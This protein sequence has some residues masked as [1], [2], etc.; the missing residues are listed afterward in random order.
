[1]SE[2]HRRPSEEVC[3]CKCI[4][5]ELPG[6]VLRLARFSWRNCEGR[7]AAA[8]R[9]TKP[10]TAALW[11]TSEPASSLLERTLVRLLRGEHDGRPARRDARAGPAL[12]RS[13]QLVGGGL[14]EIPR[15]VYAAHP[16]DSFT[17]AGPLGRL[18]GWVYKRLRR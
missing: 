18:I 1:M 15:T 3:F 16:W 4:S 8:S 2:N 17:E 13:A 10:I 14:Y 5:E 7:R 11:F 6:A 12:P 9:I